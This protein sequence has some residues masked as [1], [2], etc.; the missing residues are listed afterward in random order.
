MCGHMLRCCKVRC[1]LC[2]SS[3]PHLHKGSPMTPCTAGCAYTSFV[4]ATQ[5]TS[6]LSI[7]PSHQSRGAILHTQ[8]CTIMK[9]PTSQ[10]T[11][12]CSCMHL[13]TQQWKEE[14]ANTPNWIRSKPPALRGSLYHANFSSTTLQLQRHNFDYY[15]CPACPC[16]SFTAHAIPLSPRMQYQAI[17]V[18][19]PRAQP[20][21]QLPWW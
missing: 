15:R 4:H 14:L 13:K 19:S 8:L 7:V 2:V 3:A 17:E 16:L 21:L 9:I 1:N 20:C 18:L 12:S 5:P 6:T 10:R 11:R